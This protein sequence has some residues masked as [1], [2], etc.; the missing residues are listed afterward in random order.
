MLFIRF[1][2]TFTMKALFLNWMCGH[3]LFP[4]DACSKFLQNEQLSIKLHGV[5]F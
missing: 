3:P 5:A 2:L 4:E 1:L